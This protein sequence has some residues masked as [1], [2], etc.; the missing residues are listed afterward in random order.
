M[1]ASYL[2]PCSRVGFVL[3]QDFQRPVRI[4]T[5]LEAWTATAVAARRAKSPVE[6]SPSLREP[7][8]MKRDR[9][10]ARD[11]ALRLVATRSPIAAASRQPAPMDFQSL[12]SILTRPNDRLG[13]LEDWA[14]LPVLVAH[15]PDHSVH[16]ACLLLPLENSAA[17]TP[18]D[19]ATA[20]WAML[21]AAAILRV[22]V[23]CRRGPHGPESRS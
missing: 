21:V 15:R 19:R 13:P 8:R 9:R 20:R 7:V 6:A 18:V 14:T 4:P 3:W 1:T 12:L 16:L 23:A 11:R 2:M 17:P 5:S 10:W 22:L